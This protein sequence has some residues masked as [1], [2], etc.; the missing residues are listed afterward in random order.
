[1]KLRSAIDAF[2]LLG[3]CLILL[4]AFYYQLVFH[5]LPCPLCNMQRAAFLMLGAGL[6][7]NIWHDPPSN[8]NYLVSGISAFIGSTIALFQVFL[9]ILPGSPPYGSMVWGLNFYTWA[10]ILFLLAMP[11]CMLM[12][13]WPLPAS[14]PDEKNKSRSWLTVFSAYLLIALACGNVISSFLESGFDESP[15]EPL[16]YE[17]L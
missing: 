4:I 2:A 7:R 13:A 10:Y 16:R 14:T 5:D 3:V 9:H 8:K 1:M 6:L 12:M 11:Y 17:M 15:K